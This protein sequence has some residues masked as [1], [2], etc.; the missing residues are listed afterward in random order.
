MDWLVEVLVLK[1]VGEEA[2]IGP[3]A[4]LDRLHPQKQMKLPQSPKAKTTMMAS[5]PK[6]GSPNSAA[7]AA[8]AIIGSAMA[9][10]RVAI[11]MGF[12]NRSSAPSPTADAVACKVSR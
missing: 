5:L 7:H 3:V 8:A 4:A 10:I 12:S 11:G 6:P 1:P 2:Q 9:N